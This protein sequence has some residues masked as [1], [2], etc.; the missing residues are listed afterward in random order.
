MIANPILSS[1]CDDRSKVTQW[2]A[3][4]LN[5]KK[6]LMPIQRSRALEREDDRVGLPPVEPIAL[7]GRVGRL[8][9]SS[10]PP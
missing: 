9:S 5:L 8:D 10:E 2:A 3:Q 7:L 1:L 6:S 4:R